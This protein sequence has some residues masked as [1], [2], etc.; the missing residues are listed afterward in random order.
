MKNKILTL[1]SLMALFACAPAPKQGT[2]ISFNQICQMGGKTVEVQGYMRLPPRMEC[3]S[4]SCQANLYPTNIIGPQDP[5]SIISFDV[6]KGKNKME[7]PPQNY[8]YESLKIHDRNGKIIGHNQHAKIIG[9][10]ARTYPGQANACQIYLDSIEA[11][12]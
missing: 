10:V 12:P 8:T 4:S 2:P 11:I 3:R 6:G 7:L 5:F 9:L 1:T